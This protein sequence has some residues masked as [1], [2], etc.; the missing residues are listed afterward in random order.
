M[1][2]R[3]PEGPRGVK[4]GFLYLGA[5]P[6]TPPPPVPE[7]RGGTYATRGTGEAGWAH[8]GTGNSPPA[9]LP[10]GQTGYG[11]LLPVLSPCTPNSMLCPHRPV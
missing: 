2:H 7:F 11:L 4:R 5:L 1:G 3:G 10:G 6:N 9:R 8:P